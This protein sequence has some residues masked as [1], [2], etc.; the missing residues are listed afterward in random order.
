WP[1]RYNKA[2]KKDYPSALMVD[3]T[4]NV[5]VTGGSEGTTKYDYST[6]KYNSGGVQQWAASYNYSANKN[7]VAYGIALDGSN[8]VYVTGLSDGGTSKYD[9]ATVKYNSSGTQTWVSRY[10]G[11]KNDIARSIVACDGEASVFVTG[12]SEQGTSKKYDFITQRLAMSDGSQNWIGDF[13]GTDSKVDVAYAIAALSS[14]CA[15]TI[16]GT[17]EG[18]TTKLNLETI[19]GAPDAALPF[20]MTRNEIASS[21]ED[22][23]KESRLYENYPNPFNPSTVIRYS[24]AMNSVVTLKVF[25]ILGQEVATLLNNEEMEE[26]DHEIIFD[27]DEL[28]TLSSGVYFYHL[29]TGNTSVTRKMVL[30]R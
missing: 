4:E 25:N 11:G 6:V 17:S 7:D 12:G 24:L 2:S 13:N 5:Y 1:Q 22:R 20:A 9:Y 26:G 23:P 16:A 21:L 3:A 15:L 28:N 14:T 10:N 18:K 27:A 19:H 30:V 29:Q 8:N